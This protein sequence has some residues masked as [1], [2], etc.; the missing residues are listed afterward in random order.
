MWKLH[1]Q[2]MLNRGWPGLLLCSTILMTLLLRPQN[3]MSRPLHA[4]WVSHAAAVCRLCAAVQDGL[5][6]CFEAL[7][8]QA[9]L[10]A[11]LRN[12]RAV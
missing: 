7:L 3:R 2:Y 5:G 6:S 10:S 12:L 8:A 11:V 1:L 9:R 4:D